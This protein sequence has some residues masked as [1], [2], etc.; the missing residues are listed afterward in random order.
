[1]H[2]RKDNDVF[3]PSQQ[4][5]NGCPLPL[6]GAGAEC[7]GLPKLEPRF[8]GLKPQATIRDLRSRRRFRRL[9]GA[10][11]CAPTLVYCMLL[12]VSLTGC[13]R[14]TPE[15]VK[16][17]LVAPFE[18]RYREIGYDVI[19]AARLAIREYAA[20]SAGSGLA[21]EL[22]AYDDGGDPDKAI[23]QAK[24]L[25]LDPD[26]VAVIGHWR[27]ETTLTAQPIYEAAGL[28][29]ITFTT[30]DIENAPGV[31]NLAPSLGELRTAV[32]EQEAVFT[33]NIEA[34]GDVIEEASQLDAILEANDRQVIGG[35]GYGLGQ[36][37][38]LVGDQIDGAA[39]VTGSAYPQDSSEAFLTPET[40]ETFTAGY[41]EG[42]LGIGAGP[43]AINAYQ[44]TWLAIKMAVESVGGNVEN[45]PASD[46][47][48]GAD[49]RRIDAPVYV[50]R[51]IDGKRVKVDW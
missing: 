7:W 48:F 16:I 21:V 24:K 25:A 36:F 51:W 2:A 13:I 3:T 6:K 35:P 27:E 49:G 11:R 22:V 32:Q 1:M 28:P 4:P 42:N 33:L 44:A 37:A 15:I 12:I 34:A 5:Q 47:Q 41:E 20:E 9:P 50:Y 19:P 14:T 30:G 46:L 26:V 39:Y 29:L 8:L 23:E 38:A 31:Y 18:G 17:G 45:T 40:L 43:L 10:A